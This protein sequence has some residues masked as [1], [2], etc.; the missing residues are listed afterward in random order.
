MI[1]PLQCGSA[2]YQESY[3][4]LTLREYV[5]RNWCQTYIGSCRLTRCTHDGCITRGIDELLDNLRPFQRLCS[6]VLPLQFILVRCSSR[7]TEVQECFCCFNVES[8]CLIIV[9]G[10]FCFGRLCMKLLERRWFVLSRRQATILLASA[11]RSE[12]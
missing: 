11:S 3:F 5:D 4:Q 10:E 7:P 8:K 2:T 6:R 1:A 12:R 9:F